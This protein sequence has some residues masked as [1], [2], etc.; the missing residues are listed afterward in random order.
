MAYLYRGER[1]Q[2]ESALLTLLPILR[3]NAEKRLLDNRNYQNLLNESKKLETDAP[4][5]PSAYG[6][7]DLQL[8]ETIRVMQDILFLLRMEEKEAA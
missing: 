2:R 1:Q 7:N 8:E 4:L 5:A 6:Q 3:K